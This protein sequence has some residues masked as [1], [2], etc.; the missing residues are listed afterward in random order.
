MSKLVACRMHRVALLVKG[1]VTPPVYRV[2]RA[3][4]N[5]RAEGALIPRFGVSVRG[6]GDAADGEA[7]EVVAVAEGAA[8]DAGDAGLAEEREDILTGAQLAPVV[9]GAAVVQ[10]D[11]GEDMVMLVQPAQL[12]DQARATVA[13]EGADA[14]L[15]L[16]MLGEELEVGHVAQLPL[17][18]QAGGAVGPGGGGG[19]RERRI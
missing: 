7:D 14:F 9:D 4:V 11:L 17:G 15:Q 3:R 10:I 16:G 19:R 8:G 12:R 13:I 2:R 5:G 18:G 6:D 1:E